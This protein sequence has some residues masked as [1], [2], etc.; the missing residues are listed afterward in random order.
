MTERLGEFEL[1]KVYCMDCVEGMKKIPD[2]SVDLMITSP[3]YDD[4]R[5]YNGKI[6]FDLHATG[7]EIFRVLK[8]GELV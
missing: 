5:D 6:S 4:V 8:D 3:P 7:K 2:D 1:N